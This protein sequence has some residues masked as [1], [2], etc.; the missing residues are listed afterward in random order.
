MFYP[1]FTREYVQRVL[2]NPERY[3]EDA[4]HRIVGTEEER[5]LY[6]GQVIPMTYQGIYFREEDVQRF[7]N[8]IRMA[9]QIGRKVT[10]H[11]LDDPGYRKGFHFPQSIEELILMDP[12]YDI[13]VMVGRYDIFYNDDGS[14]QF[15]EFNT[16][17]ASAMNEDRVLGHILQESKIHK[18]MQESWSIEP[19]SLFDGLVDAFM[20]RYEQIKGRKPQHT[21]I[22]DFVDKGTTL[23]FEVFRE[24]FRRK[25][26]ACSICDPRSMRYKEGKLYGTDVDSGEE[27]A[28]DFV[29]RRVVTSDLVE[30]WGECEDYI[31]A[32]RAQAFV[33]F[34]SFRSQVMHAK[35]IFS[36][37]RDAQTQAFLDEEERA[38]IEAHV[39]WTKELLDE[40]DREEVIQHKDD[41]ILKPYNS[42][43][44]QGVLLGRE[45]SQEMWEE[46]MRKV[47]LDA[48][49]YQRYVDQEPA[50]LLIYEKGSFRT[51]PYAHVLGLFHYDEQFVGSYTRMGQAGIISGVRAYY[52]TPAFLCKKK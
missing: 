35:T 34:G 44:C 20:H 27:N 13:P 21:A 40:S 11:F 28:I 47:P 37:L 43:A 26:Y 10:Q 4:E 16:D 12:G 42:Y 23:E 7:Q 45:F 31:A 32:Y 15:C 8:I 22:V 18:D 9:C 48:Y 14:F 36:M 39:P 33:Q 6:H 17:G 24:A 1:P 50:P 52:A 46:E 51:E 5:K 30:R 25:G 3:Q 41:Y 2:K 19:F 29:Y 38:W 49:I